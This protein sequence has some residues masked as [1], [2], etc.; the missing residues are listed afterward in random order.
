MLTV[1]PANT[2]GAVMAAINRP[3]AK[4]EVATLPMT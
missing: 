3:P 1:I 2:Y 4:S